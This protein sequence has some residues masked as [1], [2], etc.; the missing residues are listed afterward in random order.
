MALPKRSFPGFDAT[1]I[2]HGFYGRAGGVS[3]GDFASLNMASQTGDKRENVLE[4]RALIA[5]DLGAKPE[6][7]LTVHQIHSA[8]CLGVAGRDWAVGE[9]PQADALVTD[10]P[11][12]ALGTMSADCG[13][14]LF[15]GEKKTGVPVVGAAHAG[16]GGA[17][18]GILE[19]TV[20]N[21]CDLGAVREN[22][23][24]CLGPCIG[25]DSYEV[26]DDFQKPFIDRDGEAARF[27]A[28][29]AQAGKLMFNMPSYIL[30]RLERA[31]VSCAFTGGDC[32]AEPDLY[33]SHRRMTVEG[34]TAEGRQLSAIMI[35]P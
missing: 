24:A 30:W 15:Y 8:T 32:F 14:V 11:G 29:G 26:S 27:F 12:V 17:L 9:S 19:A 4:N 16:W 5:A 3:A 25:P 20:A 31:G 7:L 21:M 22:I 28:P 2:A 10:K 23:T 6:D 18:G 13:P 1:R 33:F 35:R 34:R